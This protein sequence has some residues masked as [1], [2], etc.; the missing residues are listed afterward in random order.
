[1]QTNSLLTQLSLT[2]HEPEEPL[3][4]PHQRAL[5]KGLQGRLT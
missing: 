3:L 2:T 4:A 1:M 5:R